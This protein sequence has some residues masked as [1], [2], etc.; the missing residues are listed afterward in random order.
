[1]PATS[2]RGAGINPRWRD[3]GFGFSMSFAMV[4]HLQVPSDGCDLADGT[5]HLAV[6]FVRVPAPVSPLCMARPFARLL[7][8]GALDG[9]LYAAP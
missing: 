6:S 4:R 1:M 2:L 9:L 8:H 7:S 3:H 5:I